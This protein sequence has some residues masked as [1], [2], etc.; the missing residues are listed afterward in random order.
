LFFYDNYDIPNFFG[1]I[2]VLLN[3]ANVLDK[4]EIMRRSPCGELVEVRTDDRCCPEGERE[5]ERKRDRE[6]ETITQLILGHKME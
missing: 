4:G 3:D 2:P 5:R 1:Q 6:R